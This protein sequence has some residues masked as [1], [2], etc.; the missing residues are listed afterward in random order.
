MS[1]SGVIEQDPWICILCKK[2]CHCRG[3]GDLY[4]PY[5]ID[6]SQQENELN[7]QNK[8]DSKSKQNPPKRSKY[9]LL[10][11]NN[12]N[13][14]KDVWVHEDCL[15]WSEG[16]RL[17]GRKIIALEDV[18]KSSLHHNCSACKT[19]G[20]TLCCSGKRCRRKYHYNCAI[21]A[22]C[23]LDDANFTLKCDKCLANT[24]ASRSFSINL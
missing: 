14:L 21:D 12:S 19:K 8:S 18:I 2:I 16:T 17:I 10:S 4:G 9:S 22:K 6:L 20:A 11:T 7:T 23:F 15:V 1:S 13:S 24:A 3:L 5:K